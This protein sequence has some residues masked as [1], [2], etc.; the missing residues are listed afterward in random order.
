MHAFL[1]FFGSARARL[2]RQSRRGQT[3][4]EYTLILAVIV[5]VCIGVLTALGNKVIYVFSTIE[6]LLDT[7]QASH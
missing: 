3:L 6:S 1:S 5:I 4:V 2:A 7:A